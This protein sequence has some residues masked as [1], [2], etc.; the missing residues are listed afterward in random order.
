[1]TRILFLLLSIIAS[2]CLG[3]SQ[4]VPLNTWGD[5]GNGTYIN[6]ILN[7]DY[8]DPDVIRVGD[9]YYMVA[10][11]FHFL[12]M[13]VLESEDMVNWK[14]LS[15]V[16]S[17]FDFPGWDTNEHYAGGSWAPAIRYHDG[18]FW[19]FFCTIDEGLFMTNATDPA[20]PWSPLVNV[21]H[22]AKWEDP[23]PFW[24]EDGQ[25][26]LGR[27]IHGAGPI[28]IHKM[29]PDGT[30]LL[31]EGR[32]VYTGP[33]A[34]GTKIHKRNGYYYLSIPEGGVEGGWQTV[35]RSTSPYGPYEEKVVMAQ[36]GS[37]VNGPHQGGWVE[38]RNGEFWFIHFQDID[39]YGRV[40]HLQPMTWKDGWPVIGADEDGDGV[41]EPVME[42]RKP[43]LPSSGVFQPSENDEFSSPDL[44]LQWQWASVPSPYWYFP[45]AAEG[46]LKLYSV[47]QSASWKNLWD[48]PNL[49]MQKFPA[50]DFTVTAKI[51]FVPNPQL[52]QKGENCGLAVMG[53]NY[54][55]LRLTDTAEGM[56][57]QLVE[58]TD[59]QD[60]SC[61]NVVFTVPVPTEAL[62]VPSS[63]R[64]MSV[65]VPPVAPLP[66]RSATMYLR[67]EISSVPRRGNVDAAQ[68]TFSYST[69]GSRWTRIAS[70]GKDYVLNVRQGRWIGA[71]TGLY[72]NRFS[73]K[74]DSGWM[75][76]DWYRITA[77]STH[78]LNTAP[79]E[80]KR[81][82]YGDYLTDL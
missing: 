54:A 67:A 73:P 1:M 7:A 19:I 26:Y 16:Y 6:P 57:L 17:R 37:P 20:G 3:L 25:A 66:Y 27:S 39:A 43:D 76:A 49:L 68:C 41:G 10:S 53:Y 38:T 28:I 23:C 22:V 13:Q 60:G 2:Q 30:K 55:T 33:V 58:C 75:E 63:D 8:S 44:G 36:G 50:K 81:E 52:E 4:S 21:C 40:V 70:N 14:L 45:D 72:C 11:D 12:G 64:Y 71:K 51:S 77:G 32:T 31:D 9:K 46:C 62:P 29:S 65:T 69:D 42:Y 24:D 18:K 48:T 74:N 59:A 56:L 47:Q 35:L 5:Q 34:E 82:K 78:G 61:E 80:M 15:Q 79:A